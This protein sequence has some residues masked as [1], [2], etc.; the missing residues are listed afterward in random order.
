[1]D[2]SYVA[3]RPAGTYSGGMKRRLSVACSLI[4]DPRVVYLDEPTT[5]MDP[6]NRRGVWDV[7]EQAKT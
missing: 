2:L 7:I 3:S 5:G 6:V 4:S 1:M